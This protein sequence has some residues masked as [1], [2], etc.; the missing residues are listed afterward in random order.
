M[1]A[2]IPISTDGSI[3]RYSNPDVD[4]LVDGIVVHE[5]NFAAPNWRIA[6]TTPVP[7]GVNA[8]GSISVMAL[9][10]GYWDV[11]REG[12]Q[13]DTHTLVLPAEACG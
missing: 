9:A 1:Y 7:S 8:G 5:G 4:L 10:Y 3:L 13:T 12:G 2:A 11:G 6:G